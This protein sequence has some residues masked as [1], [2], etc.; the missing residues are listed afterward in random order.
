MLRD[1]DTFMG[2]PF[3]DICREHLIADGQRR[4][5]WQ[6]VRIGRYWDAG[7]EVDLIA[8]DA[9]GERVAFVECKWGRNVDVA[10]VVRRLREKARGVGPF[11]AAST[12]VP[13]DQPD[14]HR[15]RTS[16][17]SGLNASIRRFPIG[18]GARTRR[19]TRHTP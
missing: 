3:E 15:G 10:R 2:G 4:L 6:P 9:A 1:L 13:R 17:P 18:Q 5:G 8:I 7:T 14:R 11:A 19:R 12:P 16:R